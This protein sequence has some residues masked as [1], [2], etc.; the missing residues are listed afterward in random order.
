MDR[1]MAAP[2]VLEFAD[3]VGLTRDDLFYMHDLARAGCPQPTSGEEVPAYAEDL[4]GLP[5]AII[6]VGELDPVRDS[7]ERYAARLRDAGVQTTL[8][9]YPG[10]GHGFLMQMNHLAR[11]RQALAEIAGVLRAKVAHPLPW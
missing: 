2:S 1:D 3:G 7:S 10:I 11:A 5:P 4:R 6:A 9:R 8:T